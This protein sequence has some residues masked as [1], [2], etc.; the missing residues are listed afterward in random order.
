MLKTDTKI[1]YL[2]LKKTKPEDVS[3]AVE[4]DVDVDVDEKDDINIDVED[5]IDIDD[6]S[7][8]N[9]KSKL[10]SELAGEDADTVSAI[11]GLLTKAQEEAGKLR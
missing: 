10:D 7:D 6:V 4:D 5:D 2:N 1:N 11:L 3:E 9:Q 8:K